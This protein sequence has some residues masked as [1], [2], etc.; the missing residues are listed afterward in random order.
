MYEKKIVEQNFC[1]T[2]RTL[3][4]YNKQPNSSEFLK[5]EIK[6]NNKKRICEEKNK[7]NIDKK[8]RAH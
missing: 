5:S 7:N 1:K 8:N 2:K 6:T 3:L 4:K